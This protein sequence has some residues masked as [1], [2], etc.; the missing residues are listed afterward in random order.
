MGDPQSYDEGFDDGLASNK[1]RIAELEME[2]A[3]MKAIRPSQQEIDDKDKLISEMTEGAEKLLE[4]NASLK[5]QL[6]LWKNH[7][8]ELA[9]GIL[10]LE[11]HSQEGV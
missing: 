2:L 7:Y 1:K 8:E 6:V 3:L 11:V 9:D 10:Q 5:E 4:E